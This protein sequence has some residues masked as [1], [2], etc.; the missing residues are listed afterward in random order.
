MFGDRLRELRKNKNLS[1]EQLGSILN[2]SANAVYSW[3]VGKTQPSIETIKQIAEYFDVSVDYL[4]DFTLD[5]AD[6]METLKKILQDAGMWDYETND[7][8]KEY[9]D[10]L[11]RQID[12]LRQYKNKDN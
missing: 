9:A 12:I 11:C 7:V 1:Q 6:S 8:S 10:I 5:D 4:F 3:E 2:V